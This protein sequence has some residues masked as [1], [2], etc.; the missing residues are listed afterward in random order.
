MQKHERVW[1]D[2]T[3]EIN[4]Q[5]LP[6]HQ[7]DQAVSLRLNQATRRCCRRSAARRVCAL[8]DV[9]L[10]QVKLH[11][12]LALPLV[13]ACCWAGQRQRGGSLPLATHGR[14]A[15]AACRRCCRGRLSARTAGG[16]GPCRHHPQ[17]LQRRLQLLLLRVQAGQALLH[18][19]LLQGAARCGGGRAG[20]LAIFLHLPAAVSIPLLRLLLP[21]LSLLLEPLHCGRHGARLP[22]HRCQLLQEAARVGGVGGRFGGR[23]P[24]L[25]GLWQ[26]GVRW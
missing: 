7:A 26:E 22:P 24:G 14:P 21:L 18:Q 8:K 1:N 20:R 6:P 4:T 15:A 16:G 23:R 9:G 11:L 17:L 25:L 19:G 12:L 3:A 5:P 10:C 2:T 13:A